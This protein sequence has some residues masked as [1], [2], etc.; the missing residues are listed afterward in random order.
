MAISV[1]IHPMSG[2]IYIIAMVTMMTGVVSESPG[3]GIVSVYPIRATAPAAIAAPKE[4][5]ILSTKLYT[6]V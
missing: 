3:C 5:M 2:K 1:Q 6:P 4:E